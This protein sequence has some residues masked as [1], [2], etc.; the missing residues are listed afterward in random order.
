[1]AATVNVTFTAKLVDGAGAALTS[2]GVKAQRVDVSTLQATTMATADTVTGTSNA[3]TGIISLT[4]TGYDITPTKY[5]ITLPDGQYFYLPIPS[6][7]KA[8]DVGQIVCSGTP[9]KSVKDITATVCENLFVVGQDLASASTIVATCDLHSVTGT[10]AITA[11]TSNR[12]LGKPLFLLT[13]STASIADSG[14]FK[15]S[16]AFTGSAD[17]IITL[18]T[19]DGSTW[20]EAGRSAN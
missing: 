9:C 14:N 16:A 19:L 6:N 18:V 13:T 3:S 2:V 10:T 5:K 4:L 11:I 8:I 7:A 17:D 1:M 12:P 15:L 20:Y